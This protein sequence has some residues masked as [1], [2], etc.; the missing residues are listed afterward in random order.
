MTDFG[1]SMT[2]RRL[3]LTLAAV[4]GATVLRPRPAAAMRPG[5]GPRRPKVVVE[6][7]T[8][9]GCNACPP[10][11]ALME[12]LCRG[13]D[14]LGISYNIDAW[15]YL[16]WRDTLAR[17]EFT[18]RQRMYAKARGDD[19]VYT[20]Q[21]VINGRRHVV[22]NAREKVLAAIM[23]EEKAGGCQK[24]PLSMRRAAQALDIEI[25]ENAAFAGRE[26]TLWLVTMREKVR[27]KIR[28]GENRGRAIT[29]H[30]VARRIVPAGMWHGKATR[31]SLPLGEI[32]ADKA[33]LCAAILQLGT[34][35]PIIA[36]AE[37]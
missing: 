9:Q 13:R 26:A 11:D 5:A 12:E 29:Y 37:M 28:R 32:M 31:L 17:P 15:D 25:G 16:G 22:G 20:P 10:A 4:G 23:E 18:R 7:F 27:V 3:L 21:M 35:G 6:L 2:R 1:N 8:S 24:V 30:H 36:A 34:H 33:D 14:V 19:A